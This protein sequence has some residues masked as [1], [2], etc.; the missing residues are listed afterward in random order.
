MSVTTAQGFTAAGVAAGIKAN[1]NR[2]V[3]LVVNNG[4][5][6]VAAGVFSSY[7]FQAAPVLWSRKAVAA[8]LAGS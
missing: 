5:Q 2:D 1:G 8:G 4:P 7:R 3:A 6:F